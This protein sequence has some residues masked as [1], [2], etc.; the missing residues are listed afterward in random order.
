MRE[1][2]H[3]DKLLAR[4][5]FS[6]YYDEDGNER[7]V[8]E[9]DFEDLEDGDGVRDFDECH[10]EEDWGTPAAEASR[11]AWH[12]ARCA[13]QGSRSAQELG[14]I[15]QARLFAPEANGYLS[16][17]I[18]EVAHDLMDGEIADE[19]G[20]LMTDAMMAAA[21]IPV[22]LENAI[23]PMYESSPS[24]FGHVRPLSV[25]RMSGDP[26][27]VPFCAKMFLVLLSHKK[28][29]FKGAKGYKTV[30]T[31]QLDNH[32]WMADE[33][34]QRAFQF[35]EEFCRY[36]LKDQGMSKADLT[37]AA[38]GYLLTIAEKLHALAIMDQLPA[39]AQRQRDL[40]NTGDRSFRR[41]LVRRLEQPSKLTKIPT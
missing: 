39:I 19:G 30:S 28:G 1:A 15:L 7:I 33:V 31:M 9:N 37:R 35:Y 32:A 24:L 29:P 25:L 20:G 36:E 13:Q 2:P 10:V 23:L 5:E 17:E 6:T 3:S 34:R 8:Q 38:D 16:G 27:W 4:P 22:Q 12:L 18:A 11:V 26:P 40:D 41:R 21:S 14:S